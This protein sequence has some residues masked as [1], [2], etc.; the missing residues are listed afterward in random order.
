MMAGIHDLALHY[1]IILWSAVLI[2]LAIG[3]F[4]LAAWARRRLQGTDDKPAEGFSLAD[5]RRLHKEGR[6]TTEEYERARS[7]LLASLARRDKV[8]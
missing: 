8:R 2:G 3:G 4:A 5:L 6:I 1:R 7:S